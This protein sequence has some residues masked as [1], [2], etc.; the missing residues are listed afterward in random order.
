[1]STLQDLQIKMATTLTSHNAEKALAMLPSEQKFEVSYADGKLTFAGG[2]PVAWES[3][4]Y[5]VKR[6]RGE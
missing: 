6:R 3:F 5:E 2:D 4:C 1:M